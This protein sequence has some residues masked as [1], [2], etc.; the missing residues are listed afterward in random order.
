MVPF[1]VALT[2]II[3]IMILIPSTF[4]TGKGTP[5]IKISAYLKHSSNPTEMH[6][7]QNSQTGDSKFHVNYIALKTNQS[8][9]H[10][11]S[12]NNNSQFEAITL[13]SDLFDKISTCKMNLICTMNNS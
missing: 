2:I 1:Y 9:D 8:S 7:E 5:H 12:L 13:D 11:V 10:G 3:L 6:G 4:P